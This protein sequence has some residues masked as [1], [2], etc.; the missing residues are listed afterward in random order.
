[1]TGE[2]VRWSAEQVL[3]LAP[4]A[5]S[6]KA[7]I[8]LSA[9]GPWSGAARRGDSLWGLCKG[10]GSKPYMT[11]VDLADTAVPGYKCSCPSRKFPCKHALGLLLLWAQDSAGTAVVSGPE[12][13]E[14]AEKWLAGRRQRAEAGAA[15]G[16]GAPPVD[17]KAARK[18]AERRSQRIADGASELERRLG[19]LVDGGLAGA[20]RL[21]YAAWNDMAA[22]MVDAQA[23]GLAARVRELAAIPSSG[24]GWPSRMLT[25]C[26]LLHLLVRAYPQVDELPDSL[27][28]TVRSRVGVPVDSA[29]LI[30]EHSGAGTLVRDHWLVLA[31]KD[32]QEER[33]TVRRIW[34]RG[35][36]EGRTAM[37]LSFGAAQRTP[38]LALPPGS[39][40]D[41][42][43]A[44]YPGGA[45]L[46][47]TIATHH[48]TLASS[49]AAPPG[50]TLAAALAE[51]GGALAEDPWLSSR[52]VVLAAV[53]PMPGERGAT[54]DPVTAGDTG[55]RLADTEGAAVPLR[56]SGEKSYWRLAAA[57]GGAPVTVF[58]EIGADGFRPHT[59]WS[60]GEAVEL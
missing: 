24:P 40:F 18:R 1:M 41:A 28:A 15:S 4:D 8:K 14:W 57:S 25:E 29:A 38:E 20:E 6:R 60:D 48:G 50:T 42:D 21:G 33:L 26:A 53:T 9:P 27:A 52:P 16:A 37:L 10:S 45:Q 30:A 35:R 17:E 23:P 39:E 22:R 54:D 7:G 34:L 5:A 32:T 3:G 55:W 46:R 47:A 43:L 58:G 11:A 56:C 36:R 12:P 31:M 51:Y 49:G 19:D 2:Q 59:V 13:P 44:I